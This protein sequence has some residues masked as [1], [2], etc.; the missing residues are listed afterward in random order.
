[1]TLPFT[2][3]E[4]EDERGRGSQTRPPANAGLLVWGRLGFRLRGPRASSELGVAQNSAPLLS[5]ITAPGRGP[6]RL[7]KERPSERKPRLEFLLFP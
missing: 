3:P 4:A 1:M 5:A 2:E 6:A 7:P